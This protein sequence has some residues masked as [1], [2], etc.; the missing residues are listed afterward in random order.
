MSWLGNIKIER[1]INVTDKNISKTQFG[2]AS[3]HPPSAKPRIQGTADGIHFSIAD[4]PDGSSRPAP[5][6]VERTEAHAYRDA[7]DDA[8]SRCA[9]LF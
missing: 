1:R 4:D 2:R 3:L 9:T 5:V 6:S 8:L 7:I